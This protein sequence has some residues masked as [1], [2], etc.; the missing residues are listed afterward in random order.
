[1]AAWWHGAKLDRQLAGGMDPGSSAALALRAQ[2]ITARRNRRRLADGLAGT[3]DRAQANA[4]ALSAAIPPQTGEVLAASAVLAALEGRLRAP[5]PVSARGLAML[6]ALLT[7][8][9]SPLYQP[10]GP[11]L[12]GSRLREAAA[13]LE[14]SRR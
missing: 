11:G 14:S 4:P 6:Q 13:A 2:R 10:A 12:L 7:D 3:L 9:A 5:D 8:A 1:M